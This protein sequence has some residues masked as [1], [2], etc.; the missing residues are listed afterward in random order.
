MSTSYYNIRGYK[1]FWT[2]IFLPLSQ[3]DEK[4]ATKAEEMLG[5][6]LR[7]LPYNKKTLLS[8]TI[9]IEPSI[10]YSRQSDSRLESGWDMQCHI[11]YDIFTRANPQEK[12]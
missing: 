7:Y 5:E 2:R 6:Y 1:G 9:Y 11:D 3:H 12:L 4:Y 10:D 8:F